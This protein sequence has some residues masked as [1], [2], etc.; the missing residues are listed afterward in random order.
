MS[1]ATAVEGAYNLAHRVGWAKALNQ[2]A[3]RL[4]VDS[5]SSVL[6]VASE[7]LKKSY[8]KTSFVLIAAYGAVAFASL[9]IAGVYAIS[10]RS[11]PYFEMSALLRG[12]LSKVWASKYW[13]AP[14]PDLAK[15][16]ECYRS[17]NREQKEALIQNPPT[18]KVM[19][20]Y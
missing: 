14:V 8:V 17:L 2:D 7:D 20:G 5:A 19:G 12:T 16:N 18:T 3:A 9:L 11:T 6:R 13:S 4:L 10:F 15:E 1:I